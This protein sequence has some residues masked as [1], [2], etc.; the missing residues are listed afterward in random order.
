MINELSLEPFNKFNCIA[1]LNT[2]YPIEEPDVNEY[3]TAAMLAHQR[4]ALWR[5]ITGVERNGSAIL[6]TLRTSSGGWAGVSEAVHAYLRLSLDM[7][8]KADE[9]AR[10]SSIDSS[11][12]ED[13]IDIIAA[14]RSQERK[15]K[16][17]SFLKRDTIIS[18]DED[19]GV[20]SSTLERIVRGLARLGSTPAKKGYEGDGRTG[21]DDLGMRY[22]WRGRGDRGS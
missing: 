9:L 1:I 12:T 13:T 5:Y 15:R 8:H 18:S 7:V 21:E 19:L 2:L 6:E 16:K 11:Q 22:G 4:Y 20:K 17:T 14:V 10:P 3:L